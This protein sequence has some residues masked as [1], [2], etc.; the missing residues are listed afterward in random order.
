M[1]I[2]K[3]KPIDQLMDSVKKTD[4]KRNL[5]ARDIAALGIGAVVGVGI[6]VA[7]GEGAHAAGPAIILSFILAG[8]VACLCGLCYCELVTMFPVAGSTYSYAYIAFGEFVAMIIGWCLTAEYSVAASAVASGW[9]GTFRGILQSVGIT[10]PQAISA[11]PS[12]GGIIDLP[13]V[14]IILIL[15]GLLCYGMS[16]SAK[17]NDIIVGVKIFIILLFIVLG[18]SHI[19]IANYKPF[20]PYSWKGVF[21]GAST[22]FFSFLGFDAIATSAEEAEDPKKG[23]SRGIILCL[24]VVCFLYVSVAAVLTGIV[25]Y[26][27]IISENALPA[28]LQRIGINWGSALVGV[29][30]I[31]GMISTMIAVLYGQVRVFMAMSRDGLIPEGFCKIHKTHKTPY[32]ATIIAGSIAAAIAG[33]LPLDIIMEFVSIGTLLSFMV[34]SAG[35]IYLRK[36]MP[37]IERRFKCPGVPFTPIV[38]ILCCLA[39]LV[40]MRAITWIGF[41]V[42]LVI[43]IVVYFTYGRFHSVVQN[44]EPQAFRQ[45]NSK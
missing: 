19:H 43:G 45:L 27:E 29:G 7:T 36:T 31:L 21:T 13:A 4:L 39:L 16:E 15:T 14:L 38:T 8:I 37:E 20:M 11:S 32:I 34:V 12:K 30:A 5:K 18:L 17:V 40:S 2:F 3:K 42:W 24:M 9:S 26:K 10:L 23:V 22:V 1:N 6:F 35:V 41:C 44:E 33:F 25:P 28:A